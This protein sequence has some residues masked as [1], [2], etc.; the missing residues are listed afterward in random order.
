VG[1]P[2][3]RVPADDEPRYPVTS[4]GHCWQHGD[5]LLPKTCLYE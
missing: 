1:V 3:K 4:E 2:G 5:L